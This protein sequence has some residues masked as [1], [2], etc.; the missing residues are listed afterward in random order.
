VDQATVSAMNTINIVLD[1]ILVAAAIWMIVAARGIGGLVGRTLTFIVIGAII[2]GVAHLVATVGS[3]VLALNG[4]LNN[5]IHRI[6]VLIGF[7]FLI[8]GFRQLGELKR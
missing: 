2:L 4:T 3:S 5:L 8:F 7:V 6:I 1:F